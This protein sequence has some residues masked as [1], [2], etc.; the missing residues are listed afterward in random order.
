ME[1]SQAKV[2][3]LGK[4]RCHELPCWASQ[5]KHLDYTKSVTRSVFLG[6]FIETCTKD[7]KEGSESC[8]LEALLL[9]L[10]GGPRRATPKQ[11]RRG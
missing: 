3:D 7:S 10:F 5:A 9:S 8:R 2:T 4:A 6:A 11:W 1:R